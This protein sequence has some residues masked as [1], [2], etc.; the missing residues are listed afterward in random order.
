MKWLKGHYNHQ[1][2]S[3]YHPV[4]VYLTHLNKFAIIYPTYSI[5]IDHNQERITA[6]N[7]SFLT[8]FPGE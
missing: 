1:F 7:T 3:S 4:F 2:Y 6:Q 8:K 5:D